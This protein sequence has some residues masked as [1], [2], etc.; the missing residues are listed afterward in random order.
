MLPLSSRSRHIA[1]VASSSALLA[2]LERFTGPEKGLRL[3]QGINALHT[4]I[5]PEALR[6]LLAIALDRRSAS[7]TIEKSHSE[8][9]ICTPV[10]SRRSVEL[11]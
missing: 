7:L 6:M 11:C 8:D 3:P 10:L 9:W 5:A 1:P 2:L 4:V